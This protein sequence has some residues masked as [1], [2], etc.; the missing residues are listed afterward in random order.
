MAGYAVIDPYTG[1]RGSEVPIATAAEL[2]AALASVWQAWTE[3][4]PSTTVAERAAAIGRVADLHE[5]RKRSSPT[6]SCA[7]WASRGPGG[8][9]G[10]VLRR[11]LPVL[12][13]QR[14]ET[15]W[16]M[17]PSRARHP[18]PTSASR[19]PVRCWASCRGTSRFYQVARFAGPNVVVGNLIL[20][21]HA[22]QCPD[23]ARA[24]E[25]IFRRRRELLGRLHE[26]RSPTT[27]RSRRPSRTPGSAASRSP[28]PSAPAW[29]SRSRRAST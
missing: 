15:P 4:V 22:R 25:Q 2:E 3:W 29:R 26:R 20:L 18:P 7:R 17:S 5:E 21:K 6:S 8:R 28:G 16:R 10:R 27:T 19:P 13:R 14:R 9:R 1:A 24:I 12:R 11:D 23:S